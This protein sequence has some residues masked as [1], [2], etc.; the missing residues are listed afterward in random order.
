MTNQ[1]DLNEIAVFCSVAEETN[2]TRAA[3]RLGLPKSTVS[4]KLTALAIPTLAEGE[5]Y[6]SVLPGLIL[7]VGVK[8]RRVWQWMVDL[9][10]R[11]PLPRHRKSRGRL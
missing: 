11:C 8:R 7:R 1:L 4:R 9:T 6:D 3:R 5:W 2:L 10:H